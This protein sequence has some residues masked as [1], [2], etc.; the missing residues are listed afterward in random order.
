MNQLDD[1]NLF[2]RLSQLTESELNVKFNKAR[3]NYRLKKIEVQNE[4]ESRG[5][6]K[7]EIEEKLDSLFE[8]TDEAE[9]SEWERP[10]TD[11]L[12]SRLMYI[13]NKS[14]GLEGEARIGKVYF[15]GSGKSLYYDNRRFQSLKGSGFKSNYFDVDSGEEYWISGPK[16]D[17][18]DRL[19][20]GNRGVEIDADVKDEYSKYVI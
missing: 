13:E 11:N 7:W 16:K 8:E 18:N 10:N 17:Q 14:E 9:D 4:L 3:R 6:E 1:E 5:F 12:Q 19:Y 2:L 15:S 20:G